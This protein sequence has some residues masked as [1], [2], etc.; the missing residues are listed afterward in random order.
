MHRRRADRLTQPLRGGSGLAHALPGPR[1]AALCGLLFGLVLGGGQRSVAGPQDEVTRRDWGVA[2]FRAP[3]RWELLPNDRPSYPQLLAWASRGEGADRA[4][5]TLI[6]KRLP[7]AGTLKSMIDEALVLRDPGVSRAHA[8]IES[9]P[10]LPAEPPAPPHPRTAASR[11]ATAW[12]SHP[13][14]LEARSQHRCGESP[15]RRFPLPVED[16]TY[17]RTVADAR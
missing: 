14:G 3:P 10:A 15:G 1:V 6:G 4:V 16:D 2:G 17:C 7:A 8:Q 12:P 9:Q 11:P 5:I 13:Q